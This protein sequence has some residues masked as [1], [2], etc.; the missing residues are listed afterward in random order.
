MLTIKSNKL[1]LIFLFLFIGCQTS[2]KEDKIAYTFLKP[3]YDSVSMEALN[4]T[5]H[6]V[7]N[8]D[9]Y[10]D[11]ESFNLFQ[12]HSIPYIS[13]YDQR[14]Q[15]VNIYR[16]SDQKLK[17]KFELERWFNNHRLYKT[18]VYVK[19]LDSILVSNKNTVYLFD[20]IGIRHNKMEFEDKSI[21][22]DNTNPPIFKWGRLIAST[23]PSLDEESFEELR[24]WKVVQGIDLNNR[25]A[26]G[27][28]SLPQI[29]RNNLYGRN[30]LKY[31]YC[32]NDKGRFVFSFPADTNIYETDLNDYNM[33]YY[34][35]S[36]FQKGD[37]APVSRKELSDDKGS[38]QY[39]IRDSY[40]P[41]YYDPYRKRYLRLAKQKVSEQDY[42]SKS[43]QR[44]TSIIF[45]DNNFRIIGESEIKD[46]FSFDSIFFTPDGNIYA[47]VNP[48][49]EYALHFVKLK[50]SE[51]K[52]DSIN[53]AKK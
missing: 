12:Q 20:S 48:A 31:G 17:K 2:Q 33:A 53:L 14:S 37:I 18:S 35:R 8:G 10:N 28:F 4:D 23:R 32:V 42:I 45:F 41:I 44:T 7:L 51:E 21:S 36:S 15:S 5:L 29:Y 26:I 43:R 49:D 46:N 34:A 9:V 40:G 16:F 13:F 11:I 39:A 3:S 6:F 50:Y 27:Y 30:F 25:S 19:N 47:R 24:N 38:L 22:F 52:N 1:F